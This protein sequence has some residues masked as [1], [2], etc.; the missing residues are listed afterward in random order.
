MACFD[1]SSLIYG[2]FEAINSRK[3]PPVRCFAHMHASTCVQEPK[4]VAVKSDSAV[5][6]AVIVRPLLDF[7]SQRGCNAIVEVA[8]PNRVRRTTV[9]GVIVVG[10]ARWAGRKGSHTLQPQQAWTTSKCV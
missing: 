9:D 5:K 1:N 6:V 8:Q 2:D 4:T 3:A 7:E 10:S